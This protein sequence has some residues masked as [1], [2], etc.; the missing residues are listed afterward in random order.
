[1]AGLGD[2]E[3]LPSAAEISQRL[4][5]EASAVLAS[6]LDYAATLQRVAELAVPTLADWCFVSLPDGPWLEQVAAVHSDPEKLEFVADY[7]RRWP[8][9]ISD[10]SGSAE[11]FR[12]GVPQLIPELTDEILAA[13]PDRSTSSSAE[14]S[15]SFRRDSSCFKAKHTSRDFVKSGR[16]R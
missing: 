11:V 6:S 10:R 4:L 5:S 14:L 15:A 16:K 2:A 12:T 9:Q 7:T 1:M 13:S 8:T 3:P